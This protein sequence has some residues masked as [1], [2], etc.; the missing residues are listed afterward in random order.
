MLRRRPRRLSES[1][2]D[3]LARRVAPQSRSRRRPITG[4]FGWPRAT[5]TPPQDLDGPEDAL[6]SGE[7]IDERHRQPVAS[8]T[9]PSIPQRRPR[10]QLQRFADGVAHRDL[11]LLEGPPEVSR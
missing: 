3:F 6:L 4:R 10:R 8:R 11:A 2:P 5:A 9:T 7:R 1:M